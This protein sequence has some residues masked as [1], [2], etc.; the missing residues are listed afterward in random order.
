MG[1]S[2]MIILDSQAL[3]C[4]EMVWEVSYNQQ[5]DE[6][7]E[8]AFEHII[9]VEGETVAPADSQGISKFGITKRAW[10]DFKKSKATDATIRGLSKEQARQFYHQ[11]YWR[12]MGLDQ[13]R[14][15][16]VAIALFD[17]LVHRGP[18]GG[19]EFIRAFINTMIQNQFVQLTGIMDPQLIMVINSF[20]AVEFVLEF[21]KAIQRGYVRLAVKDHKKLHYLR[22]WLERSYVVL[23]LLEHELDDKLV[24]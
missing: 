21:F 8:M 4:Q 15:P 3:H 16:A 13:I 20:D 11:V 9:S 18:T 17:Q 22:G 12:G 23:E 24:E 19:A 10:G 14:S 5:Q 1:G 6:I 2:I 7:W